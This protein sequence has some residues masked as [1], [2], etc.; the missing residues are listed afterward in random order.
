MIFDKWFYSKYLG[1]EASEKQWCKVMNYNS[2]ITVSSLFLWGY[3]KP[4]L[5][6]YEIT[7]TM[8]KPAH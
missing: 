2:Q 8:V 7:F 1:A 5:V 3:I 4:F 6:N